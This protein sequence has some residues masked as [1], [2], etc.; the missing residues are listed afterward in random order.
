MKYTKEEIREAVIAELKEQYQPVPNIFGERQSKEFLRVLDAAFKR[1][2]DEQFREY[3]IRNAVI[4]IIINR[5]NESFSD[6][7]HNHEQA[8]LIDALHSIKELI[9]PDRFNVTLPDRLPDMQKVCDN[10]G[11]KEPMI[12]QD[13]YAAEVF[14]TDE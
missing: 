8:R 14:R 2:P 3:P 1:L 4:D 13:C 6:G 7:F 9:P 11:K 5:S 10:C 12:C